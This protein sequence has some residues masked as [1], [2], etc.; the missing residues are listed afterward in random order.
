MIDVMRER[1]CMISTVKYIE[2]IRDDEDSLSY[3]CMEMS[4]SLL[5]DT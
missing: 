4:L 3:L 5:Y 1:E 2:Y